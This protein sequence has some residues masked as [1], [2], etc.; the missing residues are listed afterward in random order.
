MFGYA[1]LYVS[2]D[3]TVARVPCHCNYL[4]PHK[5]RPGAIVSTF[6]IAHLLKNAFKRIQRRIG[7]GVAAP[8]AR[9]SD[10]P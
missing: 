6:V 5:P 3:M 4:Q 8:S 10:A 7:S 1:Q 2:A 9:G